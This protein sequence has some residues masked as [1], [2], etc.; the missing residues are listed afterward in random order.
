MQPLTKTEQMLKNTI[1]ELS[2]KVD[3]INE[4]HSNIG[5]DISSEI[6]MMKENYKQLK[7]DLI[8]L[9]KLVIIHQ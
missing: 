4:E 9:D 5:E 2:Q 6:Q 8:T 1:L 3:G 7:E